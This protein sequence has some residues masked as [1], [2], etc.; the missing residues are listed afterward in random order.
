MRSLNNRI[1]DAMMSLQVAFMK[2][3][4]FDW[5][6]DWD[7]MVVAYPYEWSAPEVQ[8][9]GRPLAATWRPREMV[10]ARQ[11]N[12]NPDFPSLMLSRFL[13][14]FSARALEALYP[15]IAGSVEALPIA[16]VPQPLPQP[17]FAIHVLDL[18]DCLDYDKSQLTGVPAGAW[19]NIDRP[20]FRM[21]QIEGKHIFRDR[22]FWSSHIYVSEAFT[23]EVER[24]GLQGALFQL[25]G[26]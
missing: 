12:R 16:C 20:V 19:A 8:F 6:E 14:I 9:D 7:V 22:R 13:P 18:V 4:R 11:K 24:Q 15:L 3:F 21:D 2:V 17:Y 26:E 1:I 25:E 10:V 23:L 5:S